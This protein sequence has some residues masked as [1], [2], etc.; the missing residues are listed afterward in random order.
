MARRQ[1]L[2]VASAR[3]PRQH[4]HVVEVRREQD[5]QDAELDG[6]S[7]RG[8]LAQI[9]RDR[10]DDHKVQGERR[11]QGPAIREGS[12]SAVNGTRRWV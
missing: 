7:R 2:S 8:E 10:R 11:H 6:P 5:H 3:Q 4:D 12:R 9:E 1:Q